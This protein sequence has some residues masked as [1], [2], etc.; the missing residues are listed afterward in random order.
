MSDRTP[1]PQQEIPGWWVKWIG[2]AIQQF[3][4]PPEMD[5]ITG[6]RWLADKN[7]LKRFFAKLVIPPKIELSDK[8]FHILYTFDIHVP[9]EI[10]LE[11]SLIPKGQKLKVDLVMV[12]DMNVSAA[13]CVEFLRE[14]GALFL[15]EAGALLVIGENARLE[16][17]NMGIP[18]GDRWIASLDNRVTNWPSDIVPGVLGPEFKNYGLFSKTI[19]DVKQGGGIFFLFCFR[20]AFG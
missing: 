10:F 3:P 16:K 17:Q 9:E 2:E 7:E 5:K 11:S 18:L 8:R 14:E 4:R 1:L 12:H 20:D 13:E 19:D 15:G 6:M